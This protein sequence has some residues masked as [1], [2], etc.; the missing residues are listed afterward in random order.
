LSASNLDVRPLFDEPAAAPGEPAPRDDASEP[1]LYRHTLVLTLRGR[2]LDVLDYLETVERL[3][4]HLYW[5]RLQFT[6]DEYPLNTVM[7]E[8]HT[9]SLEEEWIGV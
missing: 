9:L 3:P 2:Y 6:A 1:K 5:S 7:I 4:W 8:L